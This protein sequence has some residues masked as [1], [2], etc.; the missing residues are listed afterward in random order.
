MYTS[1][2][3]M[4]IGVSFGVGHFIATGGL[5][6]DVAVALKDHCGARDDY[7]KDPFSLVLDTTVSSILATGGT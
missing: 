5:F 7:E 6:K 2:T 4:P 3:E 1:R